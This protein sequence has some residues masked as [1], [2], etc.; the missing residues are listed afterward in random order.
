MIKK[1]SLGV[2]VLLIVLIVITMPKI[3]ILTDLAVIVTGEFILE[4][5][6]DTGDHLSFKHRVDNSHQLLQEID[7][8]Y[9]NKKLFEIEVHMMDKLL[10][11]IPT[12]H[13]GYISMTPE[14]NNELSF[15]EK[16]LLL[17][18]L[19]THISREEDDIKIEFNQE[20]LDDLS[21]KLTG[22]NL[23]D[24]II[25]ST[26]DKMGSNF[27]NDKIDFNVISGEIVFGDKSE[28][29]IVLDI[30]DLHLKANYNKGQQLIYI[31]RPIVK[32][33]E[34]KMIMDKLGNLVK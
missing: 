13:N 18:Y 5:T 2:A 32:H 17:N 3:M 12:I 26:E 22:Y 8:L 24:S 6:I 14:K 34:I 20:A 4:G 21:Y 19:M 33:N 7:V 29:A 9:F 23:N 1:I 16:Y 10:L 15:R 25:N 27:L 31:D 30:D 28:I 11:A